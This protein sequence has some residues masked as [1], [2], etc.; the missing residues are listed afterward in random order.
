M[1]IVCFSIPT[2]TFAMRKKV[3][4]KIFF[5]VT[6]W[7]LPN[8]NVNTLILIPKH[9]HVDNVDQYRLI[10]MTNFKFKVI[11]KVIAY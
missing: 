1:S 11:S 10:A 8:F 6:G 2:K 7:I 3:N 5:F 4:F 9:P